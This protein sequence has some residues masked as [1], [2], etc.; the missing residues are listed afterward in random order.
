MKALKSSYDIFHNTICFCA[1]DP[2]TKNWLLFFDNELLGYFA[3][4]LFSNLNYAQQVGWGGRTSSSE[5]GPYPPMG[6]GYYPDRIYTHA[7]YFTHVSYQIN[8]STTDI[9]PKQ[10]EIEEVC[11]KPKCYSVKYYGIYDTEFGY[12]LQFGGPGGNCDD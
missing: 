6:S 3:T 5:G 2:E 7:S 8:N 1:Q 11:D 9:E 10:N 4:T 12:S